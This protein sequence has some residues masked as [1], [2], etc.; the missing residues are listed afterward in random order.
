MLENEGFPP[1]IW[2]VRSIELGPTDDPGQVVLQSC[3]P[4]RRE[5]RMPPVLVD[6]VRGSA[7]VTVYD[8]ENIAKELEAQLSAARTDVEREVEARRYYKQMLQKVG[9]L[10]CGMTGMSSPKV[11]REQLVDLLKDGRPELP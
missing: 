5:Y 11:M 3:G 9:D 10:V 4:D 8:N 2:Q 7:N 1:S 6:V